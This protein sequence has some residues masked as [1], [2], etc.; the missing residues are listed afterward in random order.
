M[1]GKEKHVDGKLDEDG[2]IAQY[3]KKMLDVKVHRPENLLLMLTEHF[4]GPLPRVNLTV[5]ADKANNFVA[6]LMLKSTG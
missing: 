5:G 2:G 6:V 3:I 4:S 1:T